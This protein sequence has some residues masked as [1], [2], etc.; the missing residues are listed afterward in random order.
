MEAL[1]EGA[2]ARIAVNP[3]ANLAEVGN[4]KFWLLA[5]GKSGYLTR[6][7]AILACASNAVMQIARTK[8]FEE[9]GLT[10]KGPGEGEL[11]QRAL[12]RKEGL[13]RLRR[14]SGSLDLAA[15]ANLAQ[16]T[17]V[18]AA[19]GVG[20]S[21]G[22][23]RHVVRREPWTRRFGDPRVESTHRFD[24][25]L[26]QVP[27]EKEKEKEVASAPMEE[28][29][30]EEYFEELAVEVAT[31]RRRMEDLS[32]EERRRLVELQ[33]GEERAGARRKEMQG[34]VGRGMGEEVGGSGGRRERVMD[35][36]MGEASDVPAVRRKLEEE[37]EREFI[38]RRARARLAVES[39]ARDARR[40]E[41]EGTSDRSD[42]QRH[43][44][45][46][47]VEGRSQRGEGNVEGEGEED[48]GE[49]ER[50]R[51][52]EGTPLPGEERYEEGEWSIARLKRGDEAAC[53]GMKF[54]G[55][56]CDVL[57]FEKTR[58]PNSNG[59]LVLFK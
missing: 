44:D 19:E 41:G 24:K 58:H 17:G 49:E 35:E 7:E 14:R 43:G 6:K 21:G 18:A 15:V 13:E 45:T 42:G 52:E 32:E 1:R 57:H 16:R 27:R 22:G 48:V 38:L 33:E 31:K 37:D 47:E 59:V 40:R 23:E 5:G 30:H 11:Q 20:G 12:A 9:K 8:V 29:R 10:G 26:E 2:E 53:V 46:E 55:G 28:D 56:R 50:R 3:S 39:G 34:E 36:V 54:G 4:H 25:V 51:E